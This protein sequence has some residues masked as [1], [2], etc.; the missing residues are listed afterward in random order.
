MLA[1]AVGGY[2]LGSIPFGVIATRLGGAGDITK[3]GSGNIGATNVLRTGRKDLAALTLIGDVGKGILAVLLA[4]LLAHDPAVTAVAGGAA[5]LGHLFPVWLK[6]K[7]GKGVATFFGVML[8]A[9]LMP[10]AGLLAAAT[11]IAM[12]FL[13]RISS[14]AALTAAALAP[15]Y[16]LITDEPYAYLWLA[17]FM[18]VLIFIRHRANIGRLL[19]GEEPKIGAGKKK[20]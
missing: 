13:F 10:W 17:L 15:I 14:L 7:G 20:D 3:V 12:A 19:K 11:W 1:A 2:L 8:F 18:A 9:P 5:F 16:I 4:K 6:F